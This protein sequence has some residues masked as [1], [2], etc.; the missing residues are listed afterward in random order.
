MSF[1]GILHGSGEGSETMLVCDLGDLDC[2]LEMVS[3]LGDFCFIQI[4]RL[5]SCESIRAS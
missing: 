5:C 1:G 4:G 3:D 2:F